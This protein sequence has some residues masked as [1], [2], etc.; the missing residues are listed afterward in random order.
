MKII[1][2]GA[3]FAGLNAAKILAKNPNTSITLID[4]VNYHLFQPLLYQ[5][6]TGALSPSEMAYPIRS[7]FK[8]NKNVHVMLDE[9]VAI[10]RQSKNV[11]LK[12]G[13]V[14]PYHKLVVA[15]GAKDFYFG[16]T[17]WE[18]HALGIKELDHA[19]RVRRRIFLAFEKAEIESNTQKRKMY[20][21]FVVI[22]GGPTGVEMAGAIAEI[23]R[24][25]LAQD[26]RHISP[27][28]A[29]ITLV[30]AGDRILSSFAPSLSARA[31]KDLEK[32]GVRVLTGVRVQ[33]ISDSTVGL[34]NGE[35]IEAFT[36]I[37]GSGV[38]P[39]ALASA[40]D[41]ELDQQ[42]RVL[43]NTNLTLPADDN[44]YVLGDLAHCKNKSGKPLPGIAPVAMAQGKWCAKNILRQMNNQKLLPFNYFDRGQMATIGRKAA[45]AQMGPLKMSGLLA[46]LA[47]LFIHVLFLV[48]FKTRLK[49]LIEWAY[50]YLTWKRG[51]R[52]IIGQDKR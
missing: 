32:I 5:V 52:L 41:T 35:R 31:K 48:G 9:V 23:A 28:D 15:T 50:L 39:S 8:K 49:V 40:L 17:A 36:I 47:W 37:W 14:L 19:I 21:N 45:I 1:I 6:A 18:N 4:K 27:Q 7:I 30:E 10:D 20:L 42:G 22:G 46:W 44:V 26:F 13:N 38:R 2:V 3:G 29:S 34:S 11:S 33:E 51:A 43:I 25:S 16:N 12:S 24:K